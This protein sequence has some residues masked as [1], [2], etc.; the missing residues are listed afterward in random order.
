[1]GSDATCGVLPKSRIVGSC[2][3]FRT[4]GGGLGRGGGVAAACIGGGGRAG[5]AVGLD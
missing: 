2:V 5:C 3:T 4:L 1:M